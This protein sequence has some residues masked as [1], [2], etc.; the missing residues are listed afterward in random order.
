MLLGNVEN[1]KEEE[2]ESLCVLLTTVGKF[3]DTTKA[4]AHMDVYFSRMKV[5]TVS[6]YV[7][8][9]LQFMLQVSFTISASFIL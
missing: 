2:V 8:S 7:S 6:P 9:R 4:R 3:L 5:L 1:P